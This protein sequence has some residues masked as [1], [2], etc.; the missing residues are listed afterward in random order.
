MGEKR[1]CARLIAYIPQ[2]E[3]DQAWLEGPVSQPGRLLDGAAQLFHGHGTDIFLVFC[4][5]IA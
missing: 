1:Q 4:Y 5:L 3:V 2:D